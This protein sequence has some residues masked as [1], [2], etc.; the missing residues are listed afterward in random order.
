MLTTKMPALP[1]CKEGQ[2]ITSSDSKIPRS[3]SPLKSYSRK[4]LEA[5]TLLIIIQM[6]PKKKE[7]SQQEEEIHLVSHQEE[8][9]LFKFNRMSLTKSAQ[10]VPTLI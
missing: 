10:T 2:Q 5:E 8:E 4:K 7:M 9:I 3:E 6:N 1:L